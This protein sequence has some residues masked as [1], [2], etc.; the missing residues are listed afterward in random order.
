[1]PN[2]EEIECLAGMSFPREAE[3]KSEPK[4]TINPIE[5]KLEKLALQLHGMYSIESNIKSFKEMLARQDLEHELNKE[6][7]KSIKEMLAKYERTL[8]STGNIIKCVKEKFE[9]N[10]NSMNGA[11][12]NVSTTS[13]KRPR[14]QE[15][16]PT[17]SKRRCRK[18]PECCDGRFRLPRDLPGSKKA[19]AG[20][21]VPKRGPSQEEVNDG[22][23][24]SRLSDVP[25]KLR[26]VMSQH[27][28]WNNPPY[29]YHGPWCA[30]NCPG[31]KNT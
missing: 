14:D 29:V 5:E 13:P 16:T 15:P 6:T 18:I 26:E 12:E 9:N 8:D 7:I 25:D 23:G 2:R 24:W 30:S 20:L 31:K 17:K 27:K 4:E 3:I 21:R 19:I 1:M 22:K 28:V 11:S 10:A